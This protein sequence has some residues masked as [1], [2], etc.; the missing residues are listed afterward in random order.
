LKSFSKTIEMKP[1]SCFLWIC[2][3][4]L[5]HNSFAKVLKHESKNPLAKMIYQQW[6]IEESSH[7]HH[8]LTMT[9]THPSHPSKQRLSSASGWL[10]M[11]LYSGSECSGQS[12]VLVPYG[13]AAY[14]CFVTERVNGTRYSVMTTC[15]SGTSN[16]YSSIFLSISL[17]L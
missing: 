9:H 14:Q 13:F 5:V 2:L 15:D 8:Q 17:F 1:F 6:E 7:D 10:Y 4:A 12:N 3:L 16:S 11:N